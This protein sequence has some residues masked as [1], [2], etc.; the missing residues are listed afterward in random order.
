MATVRE[1]LTEADFREAEEKKLTIRVFRDDHLIDS[2]TTII[3]FTDTTV[4]TQSDVSDVTYHPRKEC[5]FFE[6]RKA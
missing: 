2:K 1:L 5:Q 3:R 6:I 4:I